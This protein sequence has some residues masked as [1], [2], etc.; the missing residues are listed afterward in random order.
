[1]DIHG[2]A[3]YHCADCGAEIVFYVMTLEQAMEDESSP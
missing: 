1:M 2:T 3:I